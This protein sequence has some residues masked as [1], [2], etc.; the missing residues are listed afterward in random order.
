[1]P[2][3]LEPMYWIGLSYSI[4]GNGYRTLLTFPRYAK[5]EWQFP[6]CAVAGD[7]ADPISEWKITKKLAEG[8]MIYLR[9][10]ASSCFL[11]LFRLGL[12]SKYTS[13]CLLRKQ[14]SRRIGCPNYSDCCSHPA[15]TINHSSYH[16]VVYCVSILFTCKLTSISSLKKNLVHT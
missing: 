12:C 7:A 15:N 14:S 4:E 6:Q 1:M 11:S 8:W 9:P 13:P 16:T 10:Y 2:K 5:C 3:L